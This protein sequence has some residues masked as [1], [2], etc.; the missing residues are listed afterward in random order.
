LEKGRKE[1]DFPEILQAVFYP[2]IQGFC[3]W[4]FQWKLR[5]IMRW[6]L[7]YIYFVPAVVISGD[8]ANIFFPW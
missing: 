1:L 4:K 3:I 8:H 6:V 7:T 5:K 2:T